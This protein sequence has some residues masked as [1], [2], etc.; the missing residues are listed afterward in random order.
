[1][2]EVKTYLGCWQLSRAL[3]HPGKNKSLYPWSS[4]WSL[5]NNPEILKTCFTASCLSPSIHLYW[6]TSNWTIYELSK[7]KHS[8]HRDYQV[9]IFFLAVQIFFHSP[10][11]PWIIH[12]IGNFPIFDTWLS[13]IKNS[14]YSVSL[15]FTSRSWVDFSVYSSPSSSRNEKWLFYPTFRKVISGTFT[16]RQ[17]CRNPLYSPERKWCNHQFPV[18]R[19][20]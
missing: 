18:N 11:S 10:N 9:E 15:K 5:Q 19:I 3:H 12:R 6:V 8:L 7:V 4:Q 14:N 17:L 13:L 2:R 20:V 1:M 16:S